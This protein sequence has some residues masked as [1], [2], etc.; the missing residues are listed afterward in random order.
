M[1]H[2]LWENIL[3]Q[4]KKKKNRYLI[5]FLCITEDKTNKIQLHKLAPQDDNFK[6]AFMPRANTDF[7]R[8]FTLSL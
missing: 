8:H 3:E 5:Y 1:W 4:V 2:R 6:I 7:I